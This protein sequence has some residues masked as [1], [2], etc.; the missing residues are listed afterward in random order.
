[1]NCMFFKLEMAFVVSAILGEEMLVLVSWLEETAQICSFWSDCLCPRNPGSGGSGGSGKSVTK[2]LLPFKLS[3][4]KLKIMSLWSLSLYIY[5]Y[6]SIC[7][8]SNMNLNL[9]GKWSHKKCKL[10]LYPCHVCVNC[11][12]SVVYVDDFGC[13]WMY[14]LMFICIVHYVSLIMHHA[15]CVYIYTHG[16]LNPVF[17]LKS[18]KL[19]F[20]KIRESHVFLE[21]Y[22][23]Q[24]FYP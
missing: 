21:K 9:N 22:G 2:D 15:S 5:M 17:W 20:Q 11:V 3:P 14:S 23:F 16:T 1:M 12:A 10:L 18:K 7:L 4:C 8:C 6:I 19:F 13:I 24:N